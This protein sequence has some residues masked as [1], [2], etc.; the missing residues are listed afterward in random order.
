[1]THVDWHPVKVNER[2]KI[3]RGDK[4]PEMTTVF[5]TFEYN[6]V[7]TQTYID[8]TDGFGNGCPNPYLKTIIAW[9]YADMPEPYQPELENE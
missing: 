5:V 3:I 7:D 6:E 1:M 2:G 9:A 4:P 8:D